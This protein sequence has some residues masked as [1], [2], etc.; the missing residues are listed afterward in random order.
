MEKQDGCGANPGGYI[1][2]TVMENGD[3]GTLDLKV[4]QKAGDGGAGRP[5]GTVS[6]H[7]WAYAKKPLPEDPSRLLFSERVDFWGGMLER[8]M[9][10]GKDE[11]TLQG[12]TPQKDE[13]PQEETLTYEEMLELVFAFLR[14]RGVAEV[15]TWVYSE[16]MEWCEKKMGFQL[17]ERD[18]AG[19]EPKYMYIRKLR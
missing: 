19:W 7:D 6:I 4:Y 9:G 12:G 15:E 11:S 17:T 3:V 16:E 1:I 5:V 8:R 14:Q 2:E 13:P 10:E 18:N